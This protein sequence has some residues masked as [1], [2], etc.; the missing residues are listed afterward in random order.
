MEESRKKE[1]DLTISGDDASK[2]KIEFFTRIRDSLKQKFMD[3][4][5]K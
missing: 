1:K 3:Y 2:L 4:K 5:S